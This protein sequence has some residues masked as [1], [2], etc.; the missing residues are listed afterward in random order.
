[1]TDHRVLG[2]SSFLEMFSVGFLEKPVMAPGPSAPSR[3]ALWG[4]VPALYQE[5]P[6]RPP[7]IGG[8]RAARTPCSGTCLSFTYSPRGHVVTT[9]QLQARPRQSLL[10]TVGETAWTLGRAA[11][12]DKGA[13]GGSPCPPRLAPTLVGRRVC[14]PDISKTEKGLQPEGVALS[15]NTFH[16]KREKGETDY[17]FSFA[18]SRAGSVQ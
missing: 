9:V 17:V 11:D 10:R 12:Q 3:M 7:F 2:S 6:D 4:R 5:S 1:M 15:G 18:L 8:P 14:G 13:P 16:L